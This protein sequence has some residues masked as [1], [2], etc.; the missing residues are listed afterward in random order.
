LDGRLVETVTAIL[1]NAHHGYSDNGVNEKK[2]FHERKI[3][4]D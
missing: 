4:R 3:F 1:K 2:V